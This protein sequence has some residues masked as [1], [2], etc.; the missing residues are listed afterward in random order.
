MFRLRGESEADGDITLELKRIKAKYKRKMTEAI[1]VVA[2]MRDGYGKRKNYIS[3]IFT[4]GKDKGKLMLF[5]NISEDFGFKT[6]KNKKIT[7]IKEG[8]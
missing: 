6:G 2:Y 5:S 8:V 4:E 1:C 3:G 7:M